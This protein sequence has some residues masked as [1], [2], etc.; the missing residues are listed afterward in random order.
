MKRS[1]RIYNYI[2]EKSADYKK[3]ELKGAVG[4][5]AQ[6][7]GALDILRINVSKE[8]NELH[9]QGRIVNSWAARCA[10]LIRNRW[11]LR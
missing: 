4:L 9:R 7:A 8:L 5:D 2:K 10:I 3:A 6:I 1:E 11:K